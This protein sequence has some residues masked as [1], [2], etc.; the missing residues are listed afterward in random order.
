MRQLIRWSSRPEW[1][2]SWRSRVAMVVGS[3]PV[4]DRAM[5]RGGQFGVVG[6]VFESL[7]RAASLQGGGAS[8]PGQ[9]EVDEFGAAVG[10]H[11]DLAGRSQGRVMTG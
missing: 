1:K 4:S 11:G 2:P 7:D 3:R 10:E 8:G 9:G 5:A 6:E